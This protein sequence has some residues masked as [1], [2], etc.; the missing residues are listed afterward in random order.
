MN[1]KGMDISLNFIILAVLALIALIVI[2]L[3]FTGGLTNLFKQ[4]SDVGDISTEKIALYAAK[5]EMYCATG[6]QAA[7]NNPEFAE[8]ELKSLNCNDAK[9]GLN[10][11]WS[12]DSDGSNVCKNKGSVE[13]IKILK[14]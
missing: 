4:Q 2:A 9:F 3:F 6:N 8:E 13:N 1:K 12:K 11:V 7:W 14:P 10:K 5:C